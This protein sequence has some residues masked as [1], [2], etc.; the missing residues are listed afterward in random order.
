M[1]KKEYTPFPPPMPLSKED[2]ML[3]SGE[4]FFSQ[5][6][7]AARKQAVQQAQQAAKVEQRKRQRE[8]AFLPPQVWEQVYW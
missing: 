1:L 6:Q 7:K 4:F 8:E 2:L 3:E 5:E